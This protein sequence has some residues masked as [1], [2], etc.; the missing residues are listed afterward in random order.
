MLETG[1][2]QDIQFAKE[3]CYVGDNETKVF[4]YNVDGLLIDCGPQSRAEQLRPWF[5][6]QDIKQ[7]ALT[8]NHEDHSGNAR[9]LQDELKVPVYLHEL[10]IPYAHEE[11]AY[12]V[13]RH[14]MW[15]N[16]HPFDPQPMPETITTG[17]Y[18]FRTLDTPGHALYHTCFYEPNQGWLFTGDLYLGTRLLVCFFEENIRQTIDTI[19]GLLKL[20]FDTIFCA[21]AG[22]IEN[23]KVRLQKKY[24]HLR[25]LQEQ[26][27]ALR[28][29]GKT[30]REID[31]ELNGFG[32][33]I[34]PLSGGEWSSY[35]IIRTI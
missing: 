14:D 15:G 23:G 6:E 16:R 20:D 21:H 8:H 10:A 1:S 32:L 27:A 19:G 11:G 2:Y 4:V 24:D 22:V 26:V 7:V 35:N 28:A 5:R 29:A 31:D 3:V 17:K 33:D 30:D 34:T 12:P 13:Y 9:W 18:T 25:E